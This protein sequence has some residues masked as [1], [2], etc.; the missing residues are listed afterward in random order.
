L[1]VLCLIFVSYCM[2]NVTGPYIPSKC[3]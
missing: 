3:P 2:L 1:F